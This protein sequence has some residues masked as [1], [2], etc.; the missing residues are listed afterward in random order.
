MKTL[1]LQVAGMTCD[2]CEGRI[3]TAVG[4]LEGVVR[5]D[6]DHRSGAVIVTIDPGRADEAEVRA[7]IER[8]GYQVSP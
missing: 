3:G 7:T 1:Q 5:T 2:G 4:Q 6:A 8:I